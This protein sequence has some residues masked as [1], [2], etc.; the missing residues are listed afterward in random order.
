MN[1]YI[2]STQSSSNETEHD[3]ELKAMP[4]DN[5]ASPYWCKY[6]A[7]EIKTQLN[8]KFSKCLGCKLIGHGVSLQNMSRSIFMPQ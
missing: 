7:E 5:G 4:N 3:D 8:F 6:S 1:L 2:P